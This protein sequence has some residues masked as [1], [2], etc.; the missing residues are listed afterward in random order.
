[1]STFTNKH[2]TFCKKM[3]VSQTDQ[4]CLINLLVRIHKGD[5][6]DAIVA[7]AKNIYMMDN[8]HLFTYIQQECL[9]YRRRKLVNE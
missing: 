7:R 9:N 4:D 2:F 3:N 1:M 6:L 5:C 8:E